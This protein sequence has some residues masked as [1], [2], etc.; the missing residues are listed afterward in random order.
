M[1]QKAK[2]KSFSLFLKCLVGSSAAH[3]VAIAF[4]LERPVWISSILQNVLGKI[5]S[6]TIDLALAGGA[7]PDAPD[8]TFDV[9]LTKRPD[10]KPYD[11][12]KEALEVLQPQ[13]EFVASPIAWSDPLT[14]PPQ[15]EWLTADCP[16]MPLEEHVSEA[17]LANLPIVVAE[18]PESEKMQAPALLLALPFSPTQIEYEAP[19]T[20][21]A[22]R[23]EESPS[24]SGEK[25]FSEGEEGQSSLAVSTRPHIKD[26]AFPFVFSPPDMESLRL[27]SLMLSLSQEHKRPTYSSL[28]PE[29]ASEAAPL[30]E[31]DPL[32]VSLP[33]KE[34]PLQ[35][36]WAA[37]GSSPMPLDAPSVRPVLSAPLAKPLLGSSV[38]PIDETLSYVPNVSF[39]KDAPPNIRGYKL[40]EI[41]GIAEWHDLF[42]IDVQMVPRKTEEDFLFSIVLTPKKEAMS[43]ALKQNFHFIIDCSSKT[44][45]HRMPIYKRAVQRALSYVGPKQNFNIYLFDQQAVSFQNSPVRGTEKEISRAKEFLEKEKYKS[46]SRR[47]DLLSI[48][49][50]IAAMPNQYDELHTVILL[51]DGELLNEKKK[52]DYY[53]WLKRNRGKIALYAASVGEGRAFDLELFAAASGGKVINSSTNAAIARKLSKLVMDLQHPIAKEVSVDIRSKNPDSPLALASSEAMLPPLFASQSY[54]IVGSAQSPEDFTFLLEAITKDRFVEISKHLSLKAASK[55]P[56]PLTPMWLEKQAQGELVQFLDEREKKHKA[57]ATKL[58]VQ[59]DGK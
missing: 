8:S 22:A 41:P 36:A 48:L 16:R 33:A 7:S 21:V 52:G 28:L 24:L 59:A 45:R 31:K 35:E 50:Q 54:T 39:G 57:Q 9:I 40:P 5:P 10:S 51:S 32:K 43:Y 38:V 4:L 27:P 53:H 47:T 37:S 49:E 13:G 42:T 6:R 56:S 34:N 29:L 12:P 20:S 23:S 18:I 17:V 26:T 3:A 55:P 58:L 30:E 19:E 11:L 44:A 46:K 1:S 2:E 25:Q 14:A 15:Q